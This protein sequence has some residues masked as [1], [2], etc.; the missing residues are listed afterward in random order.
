[1]D[2]CYLENIT[3]LTQQKQYPR[4][5]ISHVYVKF[6]RD[7]PLPSFKGD[8]FTFIFTEGFVPGLKRNL[9][10]FFVKG[11]YAH[12]VT[13]FSQSFV[14]KFDG[15]NPT[16]TS[17]ITQLLSTRILSHVEFWIG[18]PRFLTYLTKHAQEY[19]SLDHVEDL[20]LWSSFEHFFNLLEWTIPLNHTSKPFLLPLSHLKTKWP[21]FKASKWVE[22]FLTTLYM[23]TRELFIKSYFY[24]GMLDMNILYQFTFTCLIFMHA[25]KFGTRKYLNCIWNIHCMGYSPWSM[26]KQH[27]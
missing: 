17:A 3:K 24:L 6:L 18:C 8:L 1:M 13:G 4:L 22:H 27:W 26:W 2:D 9:F 21:L 20:N 7:S 11:I 10:T 19:Q 12:Q 23:K 16:Y 14:L 25:H 15:F 5:A